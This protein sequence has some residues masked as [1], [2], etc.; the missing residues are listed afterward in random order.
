MSAIGIRCS[1][2]DSIFKLCSPVKMKILNHYHM[3]LDG[4]NQTEI[5]KTEDS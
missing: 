2:P 5:K 1:F 3:Y 4:K